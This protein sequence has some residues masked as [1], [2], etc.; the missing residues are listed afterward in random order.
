MNATK[1]RMLLD[2]IK[3]THINDK[4]MIDAINLAI[5]SLNKQIPKLLK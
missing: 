4:D 3:P 2:K 1:A 5:Q